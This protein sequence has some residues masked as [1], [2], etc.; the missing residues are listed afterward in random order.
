LYFFE[1]S[2]KFAS[3]TPYK[4]LSFKIFIDIFHISILLKAYG[5]FVNE[6]SNIFFMGFGIMNVNIIR[7][8]KKGINLLF[9]RIIIVK[10]K[11]TTPIKA[12]FEAEIKTPAK[13]KIIN[14]KKIQLNLFN[15]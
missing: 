3:P 12:A 13:F 10:E 9:L 7:I 5:S 1:T 6:N 2:E 15:I 8:I 4:K 11:T 14:T